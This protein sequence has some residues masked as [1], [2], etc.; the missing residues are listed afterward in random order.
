MQTV[1]LVA[2]GGAVG[3]VLRYLLTGAVQFAVVRL[4]GTST[5]VAAGTLVV[6]LLGCLAIGAVTAVLAPRL[7]AE[8]PWRLALTA[9]LLGGFTT[10]SSFA[11]ETVALWERRERMLA[12]AYVLLSNVLGLTAAWAGWRWAERYVGGGA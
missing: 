2:A 9:G 6:N 11:Y 10:F 8:H 12:V 4:G 7:A 5:Y 1:L 3:C